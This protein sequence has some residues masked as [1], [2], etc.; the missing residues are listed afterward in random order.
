MQNPHALIWGSAITLVL[1]LVHVLVPG[2]R[3]LGGIPRSRWLSVAG[4]ISVAY[5]FVDIFPELAHRQV[6]LKQSFL[7]E[8]RFLEHHVYL[9]ALIGLLAFYG[10]QKW[11]TRYARP[12][13]TPEDAPTQA[14]AAVFWLHVGSFALY[15]FLIG[16][17]LLERP[18][19]GAQSLLLYG[20]AMAFHFV[21]N[22]YGLREQHKK[23]YRL[24]GRWVL[25]AAVIGGFV[26]S[27]AGR[28]PET[29]V[30]VLYA[31]LAGGAVMNVL[32]E[33]MPE[34]RKSRFFWFCGGAIGYTVVLLLY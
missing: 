10:L 21:V 22:D 8:I 2:M 5:V 15:N 6:R 19:I 20:T 25:A 4:G 34:E 23:T 9:V 11:A 18:K 14:P 28:I 12:E 16:Y 27:L 13:D 29:V 33:E 24:Y 30:S 3:F 17:L 1:A 26:G 32:K 31:F 7:G